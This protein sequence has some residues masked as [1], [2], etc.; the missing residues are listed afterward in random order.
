MDL[1]EENFTVSFEEHPGCL[2]SLTIVLNA[3][4]AKH[5]FKQAL[6][7][8]KK[9]V[10]IPGFRKGHA[11]DPVIVKHYFS[12]IERDWR[13]LVLDEAFKAALR[14]TPF[15]PLNKESIRQAQCSELDENKATCVI[16]F[17]HYPKIPEVDLSQC[18]IPAIKTKKITQKQIDEVVEEIRQAHC[19]YTPTK[20]KSAQKN[21]FAE[22]SVEQIDQEPSRMLIEKKVF[23]LSDEKIPAWL[24]D[25]AL[26]LKVGESAEVNTEDETPI[27]VKVT[28]HEVKKVE[29]PEVDDEL[30]KKTGA[31]TKEKMLEAIKKNLENKAL[32]G[33]KQ[34]QQKAL[35]DSL[36]KTYSFD[37]PKTLLEHSAARRQKQSEE[38]KNLSEEEKKKLHQETLKEAE[39]GLRT[40]FLYKQIAKQANISLDNPEVREEV[41]SMLSSNPMFHMAQAEKDKEK[42]RQMLSFLVDHCLE[43]KVRSYALEQVLTKKS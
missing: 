19:S 14:L 16:A 10:S 17:E 6:K 3:E 12:E 30:A 9:K 37:L 23:E 22:L 33:Q 13:N 32:D 34:A 29:L 42:S 41:S 2:V 18:S 8:I 27:L 38:N 39:K 35:E 40:Y 26:K 1:K 11:P 31:E 24:Y 28:L 36:L 21:D 7:Q 4:A 15:R 25:T 5:C 20:K 43:E